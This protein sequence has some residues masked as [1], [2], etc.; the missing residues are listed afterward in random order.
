M[1]VIHLPC[2][3]CCLATSYIQIFKHTYLSSNWPQISRNYR[4]IV[5]WPNG[6]TTPISTKKSIKKLRRKTISCFYWKCRMLTTH[7]DHHVPL[8]LPQENKLQPGNHAWPEEKKRLGKKGNCKV[9]KLSISDLTAWL[10]PP[11]YFSWKICV[12]GV[13]CVW[14]FKW[15]THDFYSL[16]YRTTN[17]FLNP[18]KNIIKR[19]PYMNWIKIQGWFEKVKNCCTDVMNLIRVEVVMYMYT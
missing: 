13:L 2:F 18:E 17:K 6:K 9:E 7:S 11:I 3:S 10:L 15:T 8:H 16:F 5:K 4:T 19:L 1:N 14:H 12:L